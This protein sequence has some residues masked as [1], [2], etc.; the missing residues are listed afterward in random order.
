MFHTKRATDETTGHLEFA[1]KDQKISP[2]KT[3]YGC[4]GKKRM[5][6]GWERNEIRLERC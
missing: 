4:G 5:N 3:M 6:K 1:F 2:G